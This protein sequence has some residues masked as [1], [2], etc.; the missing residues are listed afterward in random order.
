LETPVGRAGE[1]E[2]TSCNRVDPDVSIEDVAGTVR[3]LIREG[4][5][6]RKE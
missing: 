5:V 2:E 4:K 3:D 6:R 1:P